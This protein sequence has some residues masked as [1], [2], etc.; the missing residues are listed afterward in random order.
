ME[1]FERETA[2]R[3]ETAGKQEAAGRGATVDRGGGRRTYGRRTYG[4]RASGRF[5]A[6]RIAVLA[7]VVLAV[8]LAVGGGAPAGQAPAAGQIAA[9]GQ[10]ATV[11]PIAGAGAVRVALAEEAGVAAASPAFSDHL[12]QTVSPNGATI[13]LFDYWLVDRDSSDLA[14]PDDRFNV[15][16]NAGHD[17][18]FCAPGTYSDPIAFNLF[19]RIPREG[20]VAPTL[21]PDGYP[22]LASESGESLAYLFD[23]SSQANGGQQGKAAYLDV[24]GLLQVND[25]GYYYFDATRNFASLNAAGDAFDVYD[26]WGV[27]RTTAY[28]SNN[29]GQFFP[30]NNAT[31]VFEEK[32]G[33]LNQLNV[34]PNSPGMNHWFGMSLSSRFVQKDG[35]TNNGKTVTYEFS[36][37]D[38]VW[39]FI[40][41][42]LVGDLGGIHIQTNILIDFQSGAVVV[43]RD[44]NGNGTLDKAVDQIYKMT[45]ISECFRLAGAADRER[46]NGFTFADDTYHTLNFYYLER[47]S[48]ASNMKLRYNLVSIPVSSAVKVD[49]DGNPVAG[50]GFALYPTDGSYEV[51]PGTQ[52]AFTGVTDDT[53]MMR[54]LGTDGFPIAL[55]ELRDESAHWVLREESVPAG[56]RV[57]PDI[58]LYFDPDITSN[59]MLLSADPWGT[60]A[61]AQPSLTVTAGS[62][63][64]TE[65]G[66][67]VNT[68][69]GLLP[70]GLMFGVVMERDAAGMWHP[71]YGDA[72][73]GWTVL[74]GTGEEAAIEAARRDP[75]LFGLNANGLYETAVEDMPGDIRTYRGVMAENPALGDASSAGYRVDYFYT[76]A[77]SLAKAT[78]DNT[79]RLDASDFDRQFAAILY[80]SDVE[81]RLIVQK[82]DELGEPVAGATFG[83]FAASAATVGEDGAPAI[84]EGAEPV[85]SVTTGD[86][87]LSGETGGAAS[88]PGAAAFARGL[89]AP[90]DP[91]SYYLVET[92]APEGYAVNPA[93]VA[94]TVDDTGVYADAGAADDGVTVARGVGRVVGS[95]RQFAADDGVDATLHHIRAALVTSDAYEGAGTAWSEPDWGA[96]AAP[97]PRAM[98]L[99]CN[100]PG[101]GLPGGGAFDYVPLGAGGATALSTDAGWSK[102]VVQQ[103]SEGGGTAASPRRGLGGRDVANLFSGSVAVRVADQKT[104]ELTVSKEVAGDEGAPADAS[105][106]YTLGLAGTDGT[107]LA[108]PYRAQVL[109]GDEARGDE[110]RLGDGATFSLKAGET[111]HVYGLPRGARYTVA[112]T[113]QPA[114]FALAGIVNDGSETEGVDL[115]AASASGVV[116][117]AVREG[118]ET[119]ETGASVVFRN[120]YTSPD[121][122]VA[123]R[124][125]PAEEGL[126]PAGRTFSFEATL[127]SL[128]GRECTAVRRTASGE[129]SP[130]DI[131][132]DSDGKASFELAD[133]ESL[134]F[135][136]VGVGASYRVVETAADADGFALQAIEGGGENDVAART[137]SGELGDADAALTFTNSYRVGELEATEVA[138]KGTKTMLGRAFEP[139][140][141]F[142]FVVAGYD[143]APLPDGVSPLI[144]AGEACDGDE[145]EAGGTALADVCA[146][147]QGRSAGT[148]TLTPT[149]GDSSSLDFGTVTFARPGTYRY[150]VFEN[151]VGTGG[152]SADTARYRVTVEVADDGDGTLSVAWWTVDRRSYGEGDQ[153]FET[154]FDSRDADAAAEDASLDFAN[155]F[156]ADATVRQLL[157]VKTL[158]GAAPEG[159][160]FGFT[161]S[162][163]GGTDAAG[164]PIDPARVPMPG[165]QTGGTAG[166]VAVNGVVAFGGIAY[167]ADMVGSTYTYTVGEDVPGDATNPAVADPAGNPVA[168]RDAAPDERLEPGWA[169]RGVTYDGAPQTVTV[170]VGHAEH[171]GR[172][173]VTTAVSPSLATQAGEVSFGFANAYD[174]TGRLDGSTDLRVAKDLVGRG[175][176]EGDSYTFVLAGEEGAPMPAP[177]GE[178]AVVG[179]DTPADGEGGLRTAS[180]GDIAYTFADLGGLAERTFSYTISEQDGGSVHEGVA[181]SRALYR[182]AVALTDNGDGT[183]GVSSTMVRAVDDDGTPAED[184]PEVA[185]HTATFTNS[186]RPNPVE[187]APDQLIR[188]HKTVLGHAWG[189]G[190]SYTFDISCLQ[191]PDGADAPLPEPAELTVGAPAPDGDGAV[192]ATNEGAF[193]T[194]HFSVAGTYVYE[195]VER[196]SPADAGMTYDAHASTATVVVRDDGAGNLVVDE[197]GGAVYDNAAATTDADRAVTDAAA[198][199]NVYATGSVD[200]GARGGLQLVKTFAG[201]GMEQG[202]FSF[203]IAPLDAAAAGVAGGVDAASSA[204]KLG[205]PLDGYTVENA[206]ATLG[207]GEDASSSTVSLLPPAPEGAAQG[208]SGG[209][210]YPAVVFTQGDIGKTFAYRVVE[211]VP[212]GATNPGVVG[213]D[214]AAAAYEQA[215]PEQRALPGWEFEGAVFDRTA[216]TVYVAVSDGGGGTLDVATRAVGTEPDGSVSSDETVVYTSDR[217]DVPARAATVRFA[218][219][220]RAA[221]VDYSASGGLAVSKVLHGR[222]SYDGQF[223]F[224]VIPFGA[225]EEERRAAAEK[226]GIP[227]EGAVVSAPAAADG[228]KALVQIADG[229]LAGASGGHVVFTLE[230]A[231]KEFA[232]TVAETGAGEPPAGYRYDDRSYT[233][234][235]AVSDEGGTGRLAVTTRLFDGA[236]CVAEA[237]VD[238]T[239]ATSRTVEVP[240]ENFYQASG[241]VALTGAKRLEG[242]P[243]ADGAFSFTVADPSGDPV[244]TGVNAADGTV[245]F[246]PLGYSESSFGPDAAVDGQGNRTQVFSYTVHEDGAGETL[247]GVRHDDTVYTVEVT[248]TDRGDGTLDASVTGVYRGPDA[249]PVAVAPDA[250]SFDNVYT[251][252]DVAHAQL[253]FD[254]VLRGRDMADGEF[255]F[256][257]YRFDPAS[258]TVGAAQA[259]ASSGAAPS[260]EPSH[261]SM[262]LSFTAAD[263]AGSGEATFAYKIVE[264]DGG[265]EHVAYAGPLYAAL[266]VTDD[267]KGNLT[268]GPVAYYRDAG[269]ADPIPEGEAPTF[270]NVYEPQP[271]S[272]AVGGSKATEA[273]DGAQ[274]PD[275]LTFGYEIYRIGGDGSPALV[276]SAVSPANGTWSAEVPVAEAGTSTYRIVETFG[277]SDMGAVSYDGTVYHL[278]LDS[279]YNPSTGRYQVDSYQYYRGDPVAGNE[280][281]P[282]EVAFRNVYGAGE[283]ASVTLGGRKV[284]EGASF[285]EVARPFTFTLTDVTDPDNPAVVGHATNDGG[286]FRFPSLGYTFHL[287]V[288]EP[289][290]DTSA[291]ADASGAAAG[292]G[293]TDAG[294][295]EGE[296]P[297]AEEGQP[298]ADA[299]GGDAGGDAG[300][301]VATGEGA[302]PAD[303]GSVP[304][305]PDAVDG[306]DAEGAAADGAG[307][308]SSGTAGPETQ[309]PDARDPAAQPADGG[310]GADA[311]GAGDATPAEDVAP[312][313]GV[314]D[315]GEGDG[316]AGGIAGAL[317]ASEAVA[318]DA[319]A[320]PYEA[321]AGPADG[322]GA[323]DAPVVSD[324]TPAADGPAAGDAADDSAAG[325]AADGQ[326]GPADGS[327]GA[328]T[329]ATATAAAEPRIV[330]DDVGVHRYLITENVPTDD[331]DAVYDE[332]S[333]TWSVD[334][335]TYDAGSYLVTVDVSASYDPDTRQASMRAE[336]TGIDRIDAQGAA[337]PVTVAGDDGGD[338]AVFTNAFA[339][340]APAE[341]VLAGSKTLTGR[342]WTAA[343]SFAFLVYDEGGDLVTIGTA[344]GS[345]AAAPADGAD[346]GA[347][348]SFAPFEIAH[349]GT[350]AYRVV[351]L[352]GGETAGGVSYD[353]AAYDVA[354]DVSVGEDGRLV[355]AVSYPDGAAGVSFANSYRTAGEVEATVEATKTLAGR[356]MGRGEFGFVVQEEVDGAW[357]TVSGGMNAAA[358]DGQTADVAFAPLRYTEAGEHDYVVREIAGT[359]PG[360]AFDGA[361]F[362]VHVSVVDNGDG[363]LAARV[364]YP[365]GPVAFRNTYEDPNPPTDPDRPTDPGKPADPDGPDP[366]NPPRPGVPGETPLAPEVPRTG[367]EGGRAADRAAVALAASGFGALVLGGAIAGRRRAR[368]GVR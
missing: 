346:G 209:P 115:P 24:D 300:G 252:T 2:G 277:G 89:G 93:L 130:V 100:D 317:A 122:T 302:A 81:N 337:T 357:K 296:G 98:Y 364:S 169:Y 147:L 41:G 358:G 43:Y 362:A 314:P 269:L 255:G 306:T 33:A 97:D 3:R 187:L 166:A 54:I 343:D 150:L 47:G 293:Q 66:A 299:P 360:V 196:M 113:A 235:I 70:G 204:E 178:T 179:T 270:V 272:F 159:A 266:T 174:A 75:Y 224:S 253:S 189:A 146:N 210:A 288:P 365:D 157:G 125:V 63:V 18:R 250:V 259:S 5:F 137:S 103:A 286:S 274:L 276:A 80:V 22:Y 90:L 258:Q 182:V 78:P 108:G 82:V 340:V 44:A 83:L 9:A 31:Q 20:I 67:L 124:I 244:A 134:T 254:K 138:F 211:N 226:L 71:A 106:S 13:S 23:G 215:T 132:V 38:D 99:Q 234:R 327:A 165:G 183:L 190:E 173:T 17:L 62:D 236:L 212:D 281:S 121:L 140:D 262:D 202:R 271:T 53:G 305:G 359:L 34:Y 267:G 163:A 283:G 32:D 198:F 36:G 307:T 185:S 220:Y 248:V 237:T 72:L 335:V 76:S 290:A 246:T 191:A 345:S 117:D 73:G 92:A 214:A 315:A 289:A 295:A 107:A 30:F 112:E 8:L 361:S 167:T 350:Y 320:L 195:V 95:M 45:T 192:P 201:H 120:A 321:P 225:T 205:I 74:D 152:V 25:D 139:G 55:S 85:A 119:V 69:N 176:K 171:D 292:E 86:L 245:A 39:I 145:A 180:F 261:V 126:K 265:L 287:E 26:T 301:A 94:V 221:P 326:T 200:Y 7:S 160:R 116:D 282:E 367:D 193:A 260:G 143:G 154:V 35:G 59:A 303:G 239:T 175:W 325:D 284:L 230:D 144:G 128:A 275:G 308:A 16:I 329:P 339:P 323:P 206:A 42:V 243:L 61:Y 27:R 285:D 353:P 354:V 349:P 347:P 12:V 135:E 161:L 336:T 344:D 294:G 6:A 194:M 15:G 149:E 64:R 228:E 355:A 79:A 341:V 280:V 105:F 368:P 87:A 216:Y 136:N 65:D 156:D 333:R 151:P 311:G 104:G 203:T 148:L 155:S 240:F 278:V 279:S 251:A 366:G 51:A 164:D 313:E 219:A 304:G 181:Y 334:G 50:A 77:D 21:G 84:A 268:A 264:A 4:R 256:V 56:Y 227:L 133:G 172:E 318:D 10:S 273:A 48:G 328:A 186:Y 123:K 291:T 168:Y 324:G 188:V 249:V 29:N 101:D 331:P 231:G 232:Y 68:D 319:G 28:S 213:A 46:W 162:A 223:S 14:N 233:V 127:P 197:V 109:A 257:A 338:N 129:E 351:E 131:A 184:A 352:R 91:G 297:A 247:A 49:Q 363:T 170:S 60:G 114:G 316:G 332:A 158:N 177:G 153:G 58:P 118:E 40:D 310:A 217:D 37:D 19:Q 263:L 322:S 238:A 356:A 342:P 312:A 1:T 142:T 110:L 348:I 241:S 330:S 242:A 88:L 309:D 218:N 11:G 207:E 208:A 52:P 199:T 102:L 111:L 298:D 141:S 222:P 96:T 229:S 57:A